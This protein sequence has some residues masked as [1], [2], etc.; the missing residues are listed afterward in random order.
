MRVFSGANRTGCFDEA[1]FTVS[2][3]SISGI[4]EIGPNNQT[5]CDAS[6]IQM[7]NSSQ[8]APTGSGTITYQ[9]EIRPAATGNWDPIDGAISET[10]TPTVSGSSSAYRRQVNSTLNGVKCSV[11]SNIVTVTISTSTL[12]A[13][14]DSDRPS[15]TVCASDIG[16]ITFTATE[17]TGAASYR[18]YINGEEV[19]NSPSRTYSHTI[20]SFTSN[21]TVT[22][23]VYNNLGCF[24]EDQLIVK[25]NS[26]TAG[27]ISGTTTVCA[28]SSETVVLSNVTSG[29]ING[30]SAINGDYQWQYSDDNNNWSDIIING[31]NASFNVP[32]A[33]SYTHLTLPTK[34]IV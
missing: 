17:D 19:Q 9:W 27:V 18:F 8:P 31:N 26:L 21:A 6:E 34:R 12:T 15:H 29:T 30:S 14:I 3:N 1:Q 32:T 11:Y 4:N 23:R 25:L 13:Q 22:L 10:L 28:N 7:L 33:V 24:D 20:S 16:D 2:V 5:I